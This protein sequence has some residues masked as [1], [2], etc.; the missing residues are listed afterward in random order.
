MFGKPPRSPVAYE[1]TS[2][3][4]KPLLA[5]VICWLI[6]SPMLLAQVSAPG[7][8][9]PAA[10]KTESKT[11][12]SI[13]EKAA[14]GEAPLSRKYTNLKFDMAR[15]HRLPAPDPL[16]LQQKESQS[17]TG[18]GSDR[19]KKLRV[20]IIRPFSQPLDAFASSTVYQV[21]EGQFHILRAISEGALQLRLKFDRVALPDGARLFVYSAKNP[22]EFY[23]SDQSLRSDGESTFWTPPISG[24]EVVVEYFIPTS[25]ALAQSNR[26]PFQITEVSHIFRYPRDGANRLNKSVNVAGGC[27][28][29]VS[30]EW[31]E[32]GKSVGLLQFT[33]PDG[34]F[35]CTGTALNTTNNSGI[36]YVLTAHH[37]IDTAQA[38]RTVVGYWLYDK[39]TENGEPPLTR[40]YN[41]GW[42]MA[43]GEAGDF[44][45]LR[46]S[47]SRLPDGVRFSGWTTE[48]PTASTPVAGIHHPR[49]D[50]KRIAF[51]HTVNATCP[52]QFFGGLCDNFLKTSW[53]TGITE[54]GSSGSGL[55]VGNASD[56][57][58]VGTLTG[59][60]SACNNPT[61][62]DY[63]ARFDLAFQAISYYLTGQGCA[64]QLSQTDQAAEASGGSGNVTVTPMEGS[65]CAWTAASNVPWV[66]ITSG[67]TGSS[68][69]SVSY[70]IAPNPSAGPRTGTLTIAGHIFIII[71]TGANQSCSTT[72]MSIGQSLSGMLRPGNCR[73]V[74]SEDLYADRYS[75]T[76]T[77][78]QQIAIS[79][80]SSVF[81]SY[82]LLIGPHG[83][84]LIQDDDGGGDSNSRI[85]AVKGFY[86][87]PASGTYTIEV[88][89]ISPDSTGDYTLSLTA[90]CVFAPPTAQKM[91]GANDRYFNEAIALTVSGNSCYQ[92]LPQFFSNSPW[93]TN[94][95]LNGEGKIS[96]S[97]EQNADQSPR[98]GTIFVVGLPLQIKQ[99]AFCNATTRPSVSPVSQSINPY[100]GTATVNVNMASGAVCTWY[101][102]SRYE[103][104]VYNGLV[105]YVTGNG[106]VT[107]QVYNN[108]TLHSRTA[109]LTVAGQPI[110]I[111]Q[112]SPFGNCSPM[113]IALGQTLNGTLSASDCG[114]FVE[115]AYSDQYT[116]T[117]V[118]GQQIALVLKSPDFPLDVRIFQPSGQIFATVGLYPSPG[119]NLRIPPI[120][121]VD[122]P[123][124]GTYTIVVSSS[125][126]GMTGSY[127][128]TLTG[129]GGSGCSYSLASNSQ[130]MAA[131]SGIGTISLTV[132]GSCEWTAVSDSGWVTFPEG[133]S[134]SGSKE[135]KFSVLPNEGD[136]RYA[137]IK[138]AG[139][140]FTILQDAPC[141]YVFFHQPD[142]LY[143]SPKGDG[144]SVQLNTGSACNWTATSLTEWIKVSNVLSNDGYGTVF[145]D[146]RRN[147]GA[148]RVGQVEVAG[149][150]IQVKQGA[151]NTV[152]VSAASYSSPVAP[153][154]LV[155]VFGQELTTR[156]QAATDLPL[157][158]ILG[159]VH[160]R[161]SVV[162]IGSYQASILY[163]SPGQINFQIPEDAPPGLA[164]IEIWSEKGLSSTGFFT[165]E[166]TAPGLFTTSADGQGLAAAVALR[167]KAGGTLSYEPVAQFDAA[168]Q[169]VVAVPLDL[170]DASDQ[171]FLELYGSGIRYHSGLSKV[172][173]KIGG[174]DAEV[175]YAGAQAG[176]AGL[177]QVNVRVPRSLAGRGE[178]N[179]VLTV[180]GKTANTVKINIK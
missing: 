139:R 25:G 61:G 65:N 112:V 171:I 84:G 135:I 90:G 27:E 148:F 146:V 39:P 69:G 138:V 48:M 16:E 161:V 155:S 118:A 106:S 117:G 93:I 75:F 49:A 13:T 70:T 28:V 165:I 128:L 15:V 2:R 71:Q 179:L 141:S 91:V 38:A 10:R 24:N 126:A 67:G 8:T 170:S 100:G 167:L 176:F 114:A 33:L 88:L 36:P 57:K 14:R 119:K 108:N 149:K 159:D 102:D 156:T 124:D 111:N 143:A 29:D 44:T 116:F 35:A 53:Q 154:G 109:S 58:L 82:L 87:L 86:T 66:T 163:I 59:G 145:F 23:G 9:P 96:F 46:L 175:L 1:L 166:K 21:A 168:Q 137:T 76:A 50:Y 98:T 12:Q 43:T 134:G 152:I 136:K 20:G 105:D 47:A 94:V 157:P 64:Y 22:D 120:D 150:V 127:S 125:E 140:Y 68:E 172:T 52:R 56:P 174:E 55:W 45:L 131:S 73:S 34:E 92:N 78:G 60:S 74:L 72:P 121:Y 103:S 101:A 11:P 180:D 162:F 147:D 17:S 104:W 164:I 79:L 129:I 133:A 37:C 169:K 80:N 132:A 51:G 115:G 97:V 3:I 18:S 54:P 41:G 42:L 7:W 81:D 83:E 31:S 144:V 5:T 62:T 32:T 160:I 110:T 151:G 142:V 95:G 26:S 40:T 6:L 85:P 4:L 77:A 173:A 19:L 130:R 63:Y 113:P 122:L 123:T 107:Y 30:L 99:W 89:T 158:Q 177:D 153:G 178:V